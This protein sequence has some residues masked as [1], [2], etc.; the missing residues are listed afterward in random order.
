MEDLLRPEVVAVEFDIFVS[1]SEL[2][3]EDLLRPE[4]VA[5]E[6]DIFVS[7]IRI[8]SGNCFYKSILSNNSLKFVL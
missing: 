2:S 1:F 3:I 5:V 6:F 7:F 4:V 8:V